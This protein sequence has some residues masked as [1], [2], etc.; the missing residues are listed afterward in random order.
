MT[1]WVCSHGRLPFALLAFSSR[2]ASASRRR[3]PQTIAD[4]VDSS[5]ALSMA[6][7]VFAA[8]VAFVKLF[9]FESSAFAGDEAAAA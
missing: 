3:A 2:S 1:C 4:A 6:A 8:V 7:R 9:A 5:S